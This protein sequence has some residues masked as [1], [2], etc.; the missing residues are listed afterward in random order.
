MARFGTPGEHTPRPTRWLK[1]FT[2]MARELQ[3]HGDPA[4]YFHPR[5]QIGYFFWV[6]DEASGFGGGGNHPWVI[7]LPYQPGRAFITA[8]PRTSTGRPISAAHGLWTPAGIVPGLTKEGTILLDKRRP[9]PIDDFRRYDPIGSLPEAWVDRLRVM[10]ASI[11][12]QIEKE[13]RE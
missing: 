8:C 9:F 12:R 3:A 2:E 10:L 4:I 7:V 6:P 13:S 5:L 11:A 1:S